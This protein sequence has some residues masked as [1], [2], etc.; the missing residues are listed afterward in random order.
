[1]ETH[2]LTHSLTARR[3]WSFSPTASLSLSHHS[4]TSVHNASA[5]LLAQQRAPYA[6]VRQVMSGVEDRGGGALVLQRG[7]LVVIMPSLTH[8]LTRCTGRIFLTHLQLDHANQRLLCFSA[9]AL[10]V[11]L[12]LVLTR[13]CDQLAATAVCV[14][15]TVH[16]LSQACTS[17]PHAPPL[18][19]SHKIPRVIAARTSTCA[20]WLSRIA[21]CRAALKS[22]EADAQSTL[23]AARSKLL[24]AE[25]TIK[26]MR[27][28]AKAA[29]TQR[30]KLERA[31]VRCRPA[32]SVECTH[33]HT[34]T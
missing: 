23:D 27:K 16:S 12:L 28:E 26:D 11:A 7:S 15:V 30:T 32:A 22:R 25:Q 20:C 5:P 1:L 29:E 3:Q 18:R 31:K 33:T 34:H 17:L 13:W 6:P 24:E 9:V 14:R 8:S 10:S 4:A 2:S 19:N 21:S